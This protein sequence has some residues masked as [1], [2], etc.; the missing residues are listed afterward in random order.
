MKRT[1]TTTT[2]AMALLG[3]AACKGGGSDSVKL[4][5]EA[6]TAVGGVDMKAVV[7]SKLWTDNK[8]LLES[9]QNKEMMDAATACNLGTDKWKSV[10]F[11]MDMT[12]EQFAVVISAD[13][14]GKDENLNCVAGKIK[15]KSGKDP[16]KLEDKDGK[17]Q[18]TMEGEKGEVGYVVN[19]NTLVVTS[20]DWA[21]AVKELVDGKG[22]SAFD[23][24]LKD[25]IGRADMGKAVWFAGTIPAEMTKEG[26]AAGAKD[27]AG[28]VDLSSGL[29]VQASVGFASADEAKKKAE[30][31]Q[32]MFD[33]VKGSATGMGV[34]QTAVD[35]VKIEAK[36]AAVHFT[37]TMSAE[38]VK[39][40]QEGPMKGMM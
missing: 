18:L 29:G 11:G 21:A 17:K 13:G 8:A 4:I 40:V 5:P 7:A 16:W 26:P 6:A 36:D 37:A 35:S 3:F 38:D 31:L 30:E 24:S 27:A 39:K 22:K 10:A 20:K 19:E 12:K 32:K 14:I 34:P 33:G 25:V 2:F 23:G 28:S 15:E 1:F 9:G